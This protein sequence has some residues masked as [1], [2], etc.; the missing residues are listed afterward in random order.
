VQQ[1]QRLHQISIQ[2]RTPMVFNEPEV[3]EP[4]N[5]YPLRKQIR[6]ILT[7]EFGGFGPRPGG[8]LKQPPWGDK[9]AK[10]R[11]LERILELI[12]PEQ[13]EAWH[14]LAGKPFS[15]SR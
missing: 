3:L 6:Q 15:F 14:A 10:A 2:I 8:G 12:T 4:L 5:L 7:E 13:R 9:D 11:A 1:R